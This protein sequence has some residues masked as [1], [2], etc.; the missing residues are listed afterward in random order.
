M[1]GDDL[2]QGAVFSYISAEQR[3]PADHPLRAIRGMTDEALA[4]LSAHL[5]TLYAAGGRPSIAPEKLVRALLL[6]ALYSVRSE[7][8][9]M[10][11]LDY[12]L[13]FRWFVGLNM[14]DAIWDVTVFTKNRERLMKG[15]VAER[16]LLAIV[17]QAHAH[18]LL[19]EEHFTVD[20]TLIQAWVSRRSFREKQDPP[21]RGTGAR[22][23][24]LLR[25]THES[26]TDREARLYRKSSSGAVVPSYLGHVLTENRNGL[27]VQAL[28]TQSS[29]TAEREAALRMIDRDRQRTKMATEITLGADKSY[30][31][32]S[33]V[34]QLRARRVV[35]HVAEYAPNPKW[36]NSLTTAERSSDGF[37]LSQ[38]KRK[39]VEKVFAW[40]KLDRALRQ[41]K[42]RGLPRVNWLVQIVSAAHNLRRMQMLL[43]V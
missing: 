31:H 20:G 19:S 33:F 15:E 29:T 28:A 38:Q 23:R 13:L 41:V 34:A 18:R 43:A 8:Q 2:Q 4:E 3:V 39:L 30:Q 24:K 26:T 10:E 12:N 17:E 42:L 35:P 36:P 14:D 27:V 32:E 7:R 40:A 9:L 5:D 37:R 21:D 22:G 16:L 1:R 25:D 11:Q 6:Q